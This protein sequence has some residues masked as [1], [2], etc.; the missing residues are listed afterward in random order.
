MNPWPGRLVLL[1]HPLGHTLSP[2]VQNAALRAAGIPLLCEPLDIPRSALDDTMAAL[3]RA[4][5]A[6]GVTTPYRE[7]I[8]AYCDR[9]TEAA[10]AVGAVDTFWTAPDGA[11]VGD[12]TDADG[13]ARALQPLLPAL[14]DHARVALL[15]AGGG[16][17]AVLRALERWGNVHVRVYNRTRSRA[18]LLVGRFSRVSELAERIEQ[19]VAHAALVVNATSVGQRDDSL[20]VDAELIP[21]D[22][23]VFDLAYR[24]GGTALVRAAK[25]R[26][27]RAVDGLTMLVEQGALAFERWFGMAPDREAVWA[28]VQASR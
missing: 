2:T 3:R 26:G 21:S 7:A 4:G 9:L 16:A 17:A 22:A 20:P 10:R 11:L 8:G 24:P 13:F 5:A 23:I 18:E 14:L 19:C 6:G 1:G 25:A 27:L 12:N 28:S 15:G